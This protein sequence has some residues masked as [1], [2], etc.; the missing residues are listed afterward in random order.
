MDERGGPEARRHLGGARLPD[1]GDVVHIGRAVR[2]LKGARQRRQRL[3]LVEAVAGD[4]IV[5]EV[6]GEQLQLGGEPVPVVERR[7]Q[8]RGNVGRIR[9]PREIAADHHQPP[10]AAAFEGTQFHST[11][12]IARSVATKQSSGSPRPHW[13]ASLRSQ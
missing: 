11:S 2:P 4:D 13:I 8:R 10:V 7:L 12:V 1:E 5:L 9:A 6:G 3:A